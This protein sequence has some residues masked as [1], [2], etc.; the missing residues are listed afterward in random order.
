MRAYTPLTEREKDQRLT[1]SLRRDFERVQRRG[2]IAG[3]VRQVEMDRRGR[4]AEIV[5]ESQRR[6][7]GFWDRNDMEAT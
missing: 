3:I 1:D 5:R 7:R 6:M 4:I 2:Y